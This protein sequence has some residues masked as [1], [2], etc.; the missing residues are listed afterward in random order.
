[1]TMILQLYL[2]VEQWDSF[3]GIVFL[4]DILLADWKVVCIDQ[5]VIY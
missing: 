5:Y 4:L 3:T 1:M 2:A